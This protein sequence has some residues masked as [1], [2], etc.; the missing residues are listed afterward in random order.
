MTPT[1]PSLPF[2]DQLEVQLL[3]AASRIA[4]VEHMHGD[5]APPGSSQTRTAKRLRRG[6]RPA[7]LLA[8]GLLVV[9][10][11]ALAATQPWSPLL[12]DSQRG[13][14]TTT[15]APPPSEQLNSLGVLR[16]PPSAEDQGSAIQADLRLI[17]EQ[18]H[19]VR[20][21]YIR[22]LAPAPNNAAV[23]LVPSQRFSDDA[24]GGQYSVQDPVCVFY[25]L[26]DSQGA[27][28][29]GAFPCWTIAQIAA[30]QA[31]EESSPQPGRLHLFG[32]T[33]DGVA[34]V[35]AQFD[36]GS[37]AEGGVDNNFFDLPLN[38]QDSVPVAHVT[39]T[40]RSGAPVGPPF[41]G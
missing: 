34:K 11:S 15:D 20:T 39:W 19:G 23:A 7:L 5:A 25:P 2:L 31:I 32:L 33:P 27:T 9:T 18:E 3:D 28:T 36:D 29:G 12:G 26:E 37:T 35:S 41:T 8:L 24:A 13:H 16:R 17:G 6:R 30:G 22:Y 4:Q 1:T 38:R 21:D 10:G 40:D 14:P